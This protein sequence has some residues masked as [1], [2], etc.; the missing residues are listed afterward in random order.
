MNLAA[1]ELHPAALQ[2]ADR[3]AGAG[4]RGDGLSGLPAP[5]RVG[6]DADEAQRESTVT[7]CPPVLCWAN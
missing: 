7:L 5:V 4:G 1:G 3:G 2:A 6:P